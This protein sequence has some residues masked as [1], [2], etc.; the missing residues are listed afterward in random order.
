M[1]IKAPRTKFDKEKDEERVRYLRREQ[2][3]QETKKLLRDWVKLKKEED[4]EDE[5]LREYKGL[6]DAPT[7]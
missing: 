2:E 4:D 3:E 7:L 5:A 6:D 1:T